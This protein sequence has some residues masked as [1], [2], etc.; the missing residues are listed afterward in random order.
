MKFNKLFLIIFLLV[1]PLALATT[2]DVTQNDAGKIVVTGTC[3]NADVSVALQGAIGINT[4]WVDQVTAVGNAYE[5]D[6]NP[7]QDAT[8][9]IV[10]ACNGEVGVMET[11]CVGTNCASEDIDTGGDGDSGGGQDSTPSSG[12][13]GGG[14]GGG[15]GGGCKA[16]WECNP[17]WTICGVNLTQSRTCFD[18][19]CNQKPKTEVRDCKPCVESWICSLWSDCQNGF[20][21]R[22][23]QDEHFCGTNA[24]MPIEQRSCQQ[25][26]VPGTAPAKVTPPGVQLPISTE[27][28]FWDKYK[29]YI[30]WSLLALIIIALLVLGYFFFIRNRKKKSY[31]INELKTWVKQEKAAG[32]SHADIRHILKENTGWTDPEIDVAFA[33]LRKKPVN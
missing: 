11:I 4:V 30:I 6:F 31:N 33:S 27:L 22:T 7:P 26:F 32:T 9:T 20:Q 18:K 10:A 23:C 15:G 28:S 12:S 21:T 29:W 16:K 2:I 17:Y 5:S 3:E 25:D 19:K 13:S 8:Y 24:K 14:G 1:I